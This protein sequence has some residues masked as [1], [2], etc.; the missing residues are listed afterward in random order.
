MIM[1]AYNG[2]WYTAD[3]SSITSWNKITCGAQMTADGT[4]LL[5]NNTTHTAHTQKNCTDASGTVVGDGS[6]NNMCRFGTT[7]SPA[8]SCPSGWNGYANW[9]TTT[10]GTPCSTGVTLS[11]STIICQGGSGSHA[12]SNVALETTTYTASGNY[13]TCDPDQTYGYPRYCVA[14]NPCTNAIYGSCTTTATR[15]QIGCY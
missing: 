9:S 11:D 4:P 7:S 8:S 12:W 13:Y 14:N 6:G 15:T 5:Y 3:N 10:A 2:A 1:K